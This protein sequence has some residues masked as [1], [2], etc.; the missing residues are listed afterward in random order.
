MR[1]EFAR[2][3]ANMISYSWHQGLKIFQVGITTRTV[4][5]WAR[6]ALAREAKDYI[7]EYT[8]ERF[9]HLLWLDDDMVFNPDL[10]C[11]L[12]KRPELDMVSALYYGREKPLPVVYT[13]QF[14]GEGD[15]YKHHNL[16][17]PPEHIFACAAVGFGAMMMR[18]D[19]LDRVP[20]PWF[21]IDWRAGEDIAFCVKAR[22]YGITVWCEGGYTIGHIGDPRV[23]TRDSYLEYIRTNMEETAPVYLRGLR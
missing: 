14:E 19:V 20:E 7:S 6:N 10:A 13:E 11:F 22:E 3:L 9:T 8:G 16:V 5:D 18:R 17:N 12:I 4:V 2:S 15:K 23:V 21:T 1:A